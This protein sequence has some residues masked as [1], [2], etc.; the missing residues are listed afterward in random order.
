MF[1]DRAPALHRR[2]MCSRTAVKPGSQDS[3]R[4]SAFIRFISPRWR[5][6]SLHMAVQ[7]INLYET[8]TRSSLIL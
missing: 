5:S 1:N 6:L 3:L 2:S 7:V 8:D 4:P